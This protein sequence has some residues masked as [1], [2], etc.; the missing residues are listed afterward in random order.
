LFRSAFPEVLKATTELGA[1]ESDDGVGAM[2]GPVHPGAFEP[3]ADSHLA[4]SL[5][6]TGGSAQA[7]RSAYLRCPREPQKLGLKGA[8]SRGGA[9]AVCISGDCRKTVKTEPVL[10]ADEGESLLALLNRIGGAHDRAIWSYLEYR[11][12]NQAQ[13]SL[14]A[15]TE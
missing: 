6:N 12:G 1:A 10:E 2:N 15:I 7:L 11:C 5:D 8:L 13:F 9:S 3:R 14:T 4:P